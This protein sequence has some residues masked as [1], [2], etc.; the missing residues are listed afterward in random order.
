MNQLMTEEQADRPEAA[1]YLAAE[2][3]KVVNGAY[4]KKP[5]EVVINTFLAQ[6][7]NGNAVVD[8]LKA[9]ID[10]LNVEVIAKTQELAT[11]QAQ[12]HQ[13]QNQVGAFDLATCLAKQQKLAVSTINAVYTKEISDRVVALI[14]EL[15]SYKCDICGL[16]GHKR[17]YCWFNYQLYGHSSSTPDNTMAYKLFRAAVKDFGKVQKIEQDHAIQLDMDLNIHAARQ[18]GIMR[19]LGR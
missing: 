4:P 2:K 17:S 16:V 6:Q 10:T 14:G 19:K 15:V 1:K 11:A 9:A 7:R 8:D 5:I 3:V 18:T 12:I 13:M